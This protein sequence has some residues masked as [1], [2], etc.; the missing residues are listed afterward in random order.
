MEPHADTV[1]QFS[2]INSL[3]DRLGRKAAASPS[4]ARRHAGFIAKLKKGKNF[5]RRESG[6]LSLPAIKP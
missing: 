3:R 2:G 6:S 4:D 1:R 5:V